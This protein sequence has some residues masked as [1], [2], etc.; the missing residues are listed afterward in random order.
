MAIVLLSNDE[1]KLYQEASNIGGVLRKLMDSDER[2]LANKMV[3]DGSLIK[4]TSDDKQR[5]VC[6]F[7]N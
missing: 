7:A 6:Y 2:K 5:S 3:K 1:Q 4:G